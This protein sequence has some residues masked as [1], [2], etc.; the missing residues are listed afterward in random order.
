MKK[1]LIDK[2]AAKYFLASHP[3][4]KIEGEMIIFKP[5]KA[6]QT[7]GK[8]VI[9]YRDFSL[10]KR[11]ETNVLKVQGDDPFDKKRKVKTSK[12]EEEPKVEKEHE[13]SL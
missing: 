9:I 10:R 13:P 7:Q 5:K 8:D 11:L 2:M 3:Y 12:K 6:D 1:V 4:P